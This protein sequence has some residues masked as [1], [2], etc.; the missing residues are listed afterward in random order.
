MALPYQQGGKPLRRCAEAHR[1]LRRRG[2][3]PQPVPVPQGSLQLL[4]PPAQLRRQISHPPGQQ[5]RR[6]R[7]GS[8]GREARSTTLAC[9][10]QSPSCLQAQSTSCPSMARRSA[11]GAGSRRGSSSAAHSGG[12]AAYRTPASAMACAACRT[13]RCTRRFS[14]PPPSSRHTSPSPSGQR[15]RVSFFRFSSHRTYPTI[16]QRPLSTS[17]WP[18]GGRKTA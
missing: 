5:I 13:R 1:Q 9:D 3:F 14:R 2:A 11:T 4:L 18:G 6:L 10:R 15:R 16:T 12:A 8:V 7:N 17:L